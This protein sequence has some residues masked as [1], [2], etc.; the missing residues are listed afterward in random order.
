MIVVRLIWCVLVLVVGSTVSQGQ[1]TKRSDSTLGAGTKI[2]ADGYDVIMHR[3]DVVLL[4]SNA[5]AAWEETDT[6]LDSLTNL[7]Y[8]GTALWALGLARDRVPP[9]ITLSLSNSRGRSFAERFWVD[10]ARGR[11]VGLGG[12][13]EFVGW[14]TEGE[15]VFRDA[16][17][18]N[19]TGT[20]PESIGTI[21]DADVV[22]DSAIFC[23]EYR[24]CRTSSRLVHWF[25]I[26][27]DLPPVQ[28]QFVA[29]IDVD[30]N[31]FR[32]GKRCFAGS[33]HGVFEYVDDA[34]ELIPGLPEVDGHA[35]P[36][37][38]MARFQRIIY[39]VA[40]TADGGCNVFRLD[41]TSF[42]KIAEPDFPPGFTPSR[43]M[44]SPTLFDIYVHLHYEEAAEHSGLYSAYTVVGG[45]LEEQPSSELSVFPNPASSVVNLE[46]QGGILGRVKITDLQGQRVRVVQSAS[47]SAVVDVSDLAPG[48]YFVHHTT[49]TVVVCIQ[50]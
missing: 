31:N 37:Y 8:R 32:N 45:I 42:T 26:L 2:A 41:S 16:H 20:L 3:K 6:G 17:W 36:V 5:G 39:V 13:N 48:V 9:T 50:E 33:T 49:G 23:G 7:I 18:G 1:W 15:W 19:V 14:T 44:L 40:G 10:W 29:M 38:D 28:F 11:P 27:P 35:A 30:P 21:L 12:Y 22:F 4:S 34:W 25:E 47:S 46:V 24:I 43:N